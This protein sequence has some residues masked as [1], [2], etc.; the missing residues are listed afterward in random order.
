MKSSVFF[1]ALTVSLLSMGQ[2]QAQLLYNGGTQIAVTGG[3]ILF[4]DSSVENH[5]GL[6]SN[7]GYTTIHGSFRNG[8]TATGGGAA[9]GVYYVRGDWENNNVFTSDQSEVVLDGAAQ[10][11][12]GTSATTFYNLTLQ[13]AS[14]KTQTIDATVSNIDSLN[15]CEQATGGNN[16]FV[17]NA[18]VAAMQRVTGFVSSTGAGRLNRATNSTNTYLFPTG[19]NLVN[20]VY[21][22]VEMTPSASAAQNYTVRFAYNDPTNDNYDTATKSSNV[23]LVNGKYYHLIKQLNATTPADLTIYFDP[24]ADGQWSS[25]GRWQDLP[26]WEDL[27]NTTLVS[28]SPLSSQTKAAWVD[29]GNEPHALI[30]AIPVTTLYNFPNVFDPSSNDPLNQTFHII[31]FGTFVTVTGMRIFDRWG[32]A[33]YDSQRDGTVRSYY[34]SSTYAWDGTYEGKKQPMGN[35]VYVATVKIT[36]T[37]E[38]KTAKGNIALLR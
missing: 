22:P 7:A 33:V 9:T 38:V 30:K 24:S 6:F 31:D 16:L 17:T 8:G 13:N 28:A 35:Y 4:V 25:I 2:L 11:I 36:A 19:V 20:P 10:N 5:D 21:R 23:S 29:N 34:G 1:T 37:G 15:D 18:D 12:T 14:V 3:G 27:S 32:E 26:Q